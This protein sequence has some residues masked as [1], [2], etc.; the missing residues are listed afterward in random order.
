MKNNDHQKQLGTPLG[1]IRA[2]SVKTDEV[3]NEAIR[4]SLEYLRVRNELFR[5]YDDF[6][7]CLAETLKPLGI[8][9]VRVQIQSAIPGNVRGLYEKLAAMQIVPEVK[10]GAAK[11]DH[12][13]PPWLEGNLC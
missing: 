1:A 6:R 2:L 7:D 12:E 9:V 8:N 4:K 11:A 3:Q 13:V 10:V 5:L